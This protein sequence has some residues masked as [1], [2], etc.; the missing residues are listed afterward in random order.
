VVGRKGRVE[1]GH[2]VMTTVSRS[3]V[4]D[5]ANAVLRMRDGVDG[6]VEGDLGEADDGAGVDVANEEADEVR[7][8]LGRGSPEEEVV[9]AGGQDDGV[10]CIPGVLDDAIG[11]D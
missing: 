2:H 11:Q 8:A 4:G 6:H 10:V 3:R 5:E 9:G 1:L 7:G